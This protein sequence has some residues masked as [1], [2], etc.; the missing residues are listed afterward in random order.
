MKVALCTFFGAQRHSHDI[1]AG[2]L[3][4]SAAPGS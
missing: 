1:P 2:R 3:A 4:G